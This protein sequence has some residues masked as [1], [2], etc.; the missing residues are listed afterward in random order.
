M[1][2]DFRNTG[3]TIRV[4]VQLRLIVGFLGSRK[5]SGWWDC[6][7]LDSTG[8][9]FL[10]NVFP[11]TARA[12]ALRSTAEAACIV[13]D[14]ALGRV[15]SY[16]LFRLPPALEDRLESCIGEIDWAERGKEIESRD[17]AMA[18]LKKLADAVVK[19]PSGPVQIGVER[20]I[21]A[22]TAI[23]ELAAHYHSAFQDGIQ[24]FPYFA[25]D[26]HAR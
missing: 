18:V 7:L 21:L 10:E 2:A 8:L 15:G 24:C 4:F 3:E 12:A 9:R 25:P 11:R 19:A 1:A 20:K 22:P 6:D 16:H 23:Q 13:H 17:T 5:Q 14:K 26:K